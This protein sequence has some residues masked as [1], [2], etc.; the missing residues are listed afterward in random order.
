[1][2][3]IFLLNVAIVVYG[4]LCICCN[5]LIFPRVSN[6]FLQK[7]ARSSPCGLYI[8]TRIVTSFFLS[9][10]NSIKEFKVFSSP[11]PSKII[12]EW[13]VFTPATFLLAGI[14]TVVLIT[15]PSWFIFTASKGGQLL[16]YFTRAHVT[17]WVAPDTAR[18]GVLWPMP[19][20]TFR[21]DCGINSISVSSCIQAAISW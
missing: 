9:V 10:V 17:D 16:N 4:L 8:S 1:M 14:V 2:Q 7:C 20:A 15:S 11:L 12:G 13:Q 3:C 6:F 18:K 21:S 5:K 19:R